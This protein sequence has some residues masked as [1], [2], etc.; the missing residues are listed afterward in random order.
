MALDLL[1]SPTA[2]SLS[3]LLSQIIYKI[4]GNLEQ[5]FPVSPSCLFYYLFLVLKITWP[6]TCHFFPAVLDGLEKILLFLTYIQWIGLQ[7]HHWSYRG[8]VG[9]LTAWMMNALMKGE[10]F[11]HLLKSSQ[12]DKNCSHTHNSGAKE[13]GLAGA[14]HNRISSLSN[15]DSKN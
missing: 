9:S 2:R 13:Y 11:P 12:P 7:H 6:R 1:I 5:F 15:K 3:V 10:V 4:R 14:L 8:A